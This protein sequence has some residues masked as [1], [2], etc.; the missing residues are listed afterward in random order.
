MKR[1]FRQSFHS[2]KSSSLRRFV[3][4]TPL[5]DKQLDYAIKI[6]IADAETTRKKVSPT[7]GNPLPIREHVELTCITRNTDSVNIQA[8]LDKGHETRDLVVVVLSRRT[9]ND[10]DLHSVLHAPTDNA[11]SV[12]RFSVSRRVGPAVA[13][14]YE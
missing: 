1:H 10:L 14:C 8:L 9:M 7:P 13:L 2:A 5:L 12:E 11:P 4:R 6:G 3:A